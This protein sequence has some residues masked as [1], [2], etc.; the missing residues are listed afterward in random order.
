[1][2]PK[3]G[4]L[5]LYICMYVCMYVDEKKKKKK[6]KKKNIMCSLLDFFFWDLKQK[7]NVPKYR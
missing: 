3:T 7:I 1:M 2:Q 6:K 4:S 5:S